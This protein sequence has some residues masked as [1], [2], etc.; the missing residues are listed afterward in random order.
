MRQGIAQMQQTNSTTG[1]LS[2]AATALASFPDRI[3]YS[4][5]NQA[6]AALFVKFGPGCTTSN[7]D[8]VLKGSTGAADGSGGAI[9]ESG[10]ATYTG[11]ITVAASGSPSYTAA[12]W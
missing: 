5:Q 7:Y 10:P 6:T 11:I 12:D 9:F 8:L 2:T 3:A 4:I 1:G